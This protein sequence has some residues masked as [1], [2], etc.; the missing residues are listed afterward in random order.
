MIEFIGAA[1]YRN[2]LTFSPWSSRVIEDLK[3]ASRIGGRLW[4]S[5]VWKNCVQISVHWGID[6][7]FV[8]DL[9]RAGVAAGSLEFLDAR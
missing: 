6:R 7:E 3:G 2:H 9:V 8:N 4:K 1:G 5:V